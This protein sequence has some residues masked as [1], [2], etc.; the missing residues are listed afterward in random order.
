MNDK[1]RANI[2]QFP[3]EF[4]IEQYLHKKHDYTEEAVLIMAEVLKERN[5]TEEKLS[6]IAA[7]KDMPEIPDHP[8]PPIDERSPLPSPFFQKDL[9]LVHGILGEQRIP[10]T[11]ESSIL[12]QSEQ[13]QQQRQLFVI[14]VPNDQL[15]NATQAIEA[16]FSV[17]DGA[18]QVRFADYRERLKSFHFQEYR[19]SD[20][21]AA[22]EIGIS[23]SDEERN[24]LLRYARRL[25]QDADQ[26]EQQS[27]RVLF[28]IDNVDSLIDRLE[29]PDSAS[30]TVADLC[31]IMETLQFYCEEADFPQILLSVAESLFAIFDENF[32]H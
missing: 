2:E 12:S 17:R 6:A 28:F 31:T 16:Q 1:V 21:E 13:S 25:L 14:A 9:A 7:K 24:E 19:I 26:I 3:D 27:D 10:F 8:T 32:T 22:E 15:E 29:D 11:I 18:Y 4:L 20:L 5:I 23:F 30:F